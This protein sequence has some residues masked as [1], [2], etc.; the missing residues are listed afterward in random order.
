[1]RRVHAAL[2]AVGRNVYGAQHLEGEQ[3]QRD[4]VDV[5][6][7]VACVAV[8]IVF[9][10]GGLA[11]AS[12]RRRNQIDA[13]VVRRVGATGELKVAIRLAFKKKK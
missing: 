8:V 2:V 12:W 3:T 5:E 7:L 9:P 4:A 11:R 6:P 1:M 13:F 10:C